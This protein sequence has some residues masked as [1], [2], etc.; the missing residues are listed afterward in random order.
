ME[1]ASRAWGAVG[2]WCGIGAT[3]LALSGCTTV[4]QKLFPDPDPVKAEAF[5]H[6]GSRYST[7]AGVE[8]D[9][10]LALQSYRDAARYG[11][12]PGA[13]M[14]G[15]TFYTG[16]GAGVDYTEARR[17]L[18]RAAKHDYA[19]AQYQLG[20]L[21]IDGKGGN[22]DAAW[23]V[24]WLGMAAYQGHARAQFAYGIAWSQGI[25][26]PVDKVQAL[27][28]VLRADKQGLEQAAEVTRA[29]QKRIAPSD[30]ERAKRRAQ[31]A[32]VAK[33]AYNNRPTLLFVQQRLTEKG[34]QPGPIDGVM[35]AKTRAALATFQQDA[36]VAS[37][38]EIDEITL[39]QLRDLYFWEPLLN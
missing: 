3:A 13:Y 36:G 9:Y 8:Q 31:A 4:T 24:R 7:G 38:G 28:W 20:R 17:W 14:V 37:H 33:G 16:R 26:L 10:G 5:Y 39:N 21:Y 22:K 18:L 12:V 25:G 32:L 35:G 27:S 23:G 29:L 19:R 15:M 1:S 2:Y 11:S 34:Y 30:R 6:Q